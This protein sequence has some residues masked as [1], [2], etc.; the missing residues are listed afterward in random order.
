MS[1][2]DSV[3]A[4]ARIAL[5]VGTILVAI[6]W[7]PAILRGTFASRDCWRL[8]LNYLTPF[9]VAEYARRQA[10]AHTRTD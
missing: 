5:V 10:A 1:R 6:N 9:A 8:L 3:A 7:G 2:K 4:S